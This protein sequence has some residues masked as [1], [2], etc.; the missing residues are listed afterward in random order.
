[1]DERPFFEEKFLVGVKHI[2]RQ[3][4]QLFEILGKVHDALLA[5]DPSAG[6][7]ISQAV[8]ELLDYT[9][10]HFASEEETMARAGYPALADHQ[11]LHSSLLTQVRE[12]EIRT[13]FDSQFRPSEL[14]SF[15]YGWLADHILAEDKKFGDYCRSKGIQITDETET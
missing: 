5:N 7:T 1:M 4:H 2:D 13:E 15:L 6:P 3:H 8:V 10:T 9:H 14:A 11:E 12:L